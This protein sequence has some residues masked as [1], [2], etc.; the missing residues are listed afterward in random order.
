MN[1]AN[2]GYAQASQTVAVEQR[3]PQVEQQLQRLARIQEVQ[4]S[5][6]STLYTR[7]GAVMRGIPKTGQDVRLQ[8]PSPSAMQEV[9]VPLADRLAS[10]NNGLEEE[11][12]ALQ[13]MLSAI[14]L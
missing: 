10:V 7:L 6:V 3:T 12:T 4:H 8:P 14:E 2:V 9:L 5:L 11:N 1:G 13:D